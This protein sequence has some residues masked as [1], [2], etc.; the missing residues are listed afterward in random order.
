MYKI[1]LYFTMLLTVSVFIAIS[2]LAIM[3]IFEY[4]GL[5][6]YLGFTIA[7]L[8]N[9]A[10]WLMAPKIIESIYKVRPLHTSEAPWLHEIVEK[11][12][13]RIRIKKPMLMLAQTDIPNAFAYGG[14]MGGKKVA[15]TKGLLQTLEKD[16][17]EAVLGHELG[18]VKHRD[19]TIMMFLSVL[20][21]IFYLLYE[22]T[23]YQIYFTAGGGDN[24][25][26]PLLLIAIGILSLIIYFI[27]N[28]FLLGF[29]RLREYYADYESATNVENG[30]RKLM[31]A[32]AK[33]S[34]YTH[35]KYR[36]RKETIHTGSFKAILIA[37]PDTHERI[38]TEA[39]YKGDE[40]L[41]EGILHQKIT[42]SDRLFEIFSTHPN[43]V[44]RLRRLQMLANE[45][46]V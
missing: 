37:D 13:K 23:F 35:E 1:K 17:V 43:I 21:S 34:S 44:K 39:F 3:L 31:E 7:I 19:V 9:L 20:P 27:L 30:A 4:M 12:S 11:L 28:L 8:F 45:E 32:L 41:V 5:G 16:E 46:R 24:E 42:F 38:P 2:T 25:S 10:Q 36:K 22:I 33:I 14:V 26:S 15:V 18:H 40:E 6:L 29:S